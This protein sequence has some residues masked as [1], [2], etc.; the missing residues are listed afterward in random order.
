MTK[1]TVD[2]GDL[3]DLLMKSD[4]PGV[5]QGSARGRNL[6]KTPKNPLYESAH[7]PL[8][9]QKIEKK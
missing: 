3:I 7:F 8:F 2:Y 1:L 9:S 6:E 5:S 4:L